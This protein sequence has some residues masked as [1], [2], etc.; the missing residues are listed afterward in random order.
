MI[1]II[2]D[3]SAV[4]SSLSLLL[5]QSGFEVATAED[6]DT[7]SQFMS[8]Q[9]PDLFVL[10]MNFSV[11][12]SGDEG[13]ALLRDIKATCPERPVI[14][15]TAWGSIPLAVEGMRLGA[16]DFITKPWNND[17]FLQSIKTALS[18]SQHG[19]AGAAAVDR[20]RL[21]SLYAIDNIIGSD[22]K[23]LA[24]LETAGRVAST[25]APVLIVGESGTGK[26]LVAEAIHANS[27]RAAGP[28]V[29]VNLGGIP[30]SLFESEMFGHKKGAFTNAVHDRV[31]RFDTADG[32]TIFLDEIGD[33]DSSS[34]VKLLRVLQDRSFEVL[35][36]SKT[37]TVDFRAVSATNRNLDE[38]VGTGQFREDLFYRINLITLKLPPL[39][40]RRDDI[41]LLVNHF[42][43][44]L[45]T[46]YRRE[47]LS[48]ADRALVWL[49]ELPWPGNVRELKNVV[50]RTVL[51]S[52][53][54]LLDVEDFQIQA[55]SAASSIGTASLPAVGTATLDEM[56]ESM[57][58]KALEFHGSNITKVARSLGLSRGA[59]YRRLEKYGITV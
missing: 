29:K 48:I 35:G 20:D 59:L 5:K 6:P 7:A 26:E 12:T 17:R 34:Q 18:L 37:H 21:D 38:L 1:L 4:R 46:I 22:S 14:L 2:D 25:E 44:N 13:L 43:R 16:A 56:E 33:L 24:V 51:V 28:F 31:G 42:I 58:R 32:G 3:D 41:P 40:E 55:Q 23:L 30:P 10:D 27:G 52:K 49:A 19:A 36:T 11:S 39:R 50:E 54:D 9:T 57:I 15:I 45:K 53:R 8:R 47:N